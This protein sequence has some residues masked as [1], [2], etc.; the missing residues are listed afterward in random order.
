MHSIPYMLT[1]YTWTIPPFYPSIIRPWSVH[2]TLC[3]SSFK[4]PVLVVPPFAVQGLLAHGYRFKVN[5]EGVSNNYG[6]GL[7]LPILNGPWTG[8]TGW[9]DVSQPSR[10]EYYIGNF[11]EDVSNLS[12]LSI[13]EAGQM[14][15]QPLTPP[16]FCFFSPRPSSL[17][18]N[19][20]MFMVCLISFVMQKAL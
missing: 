19:E 4:F 17:L 10:R 3:P 6:I 15:A 1:T 5:F 2:A 8:W 14:P 20:I 12:N 18:E 7:L 9:T 16:H 11:A 13:F